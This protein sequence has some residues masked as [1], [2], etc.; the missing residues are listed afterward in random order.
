VVRVGKFQG[1]EISF[2]REIDLT[3]QQIPFK[4]DNSGA[5][6]GNKKR[7]PAL[8]GAGVTHFG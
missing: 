4:P 8:V 2:Q 6:P 5:K 3:K 1:T 7:T